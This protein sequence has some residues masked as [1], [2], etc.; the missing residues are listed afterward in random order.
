MPKSRAIDLLHPTG[1]QNESPEL[2]GNSINR[3]V[4][5][6][7]EHL[8][9]DARILD[10]IRAVVAGD[11]PARRDRYRDALLR[12]PEVKKR[13][14][15]GRSTIYNKIEAETFPKQIPLGGNMVGWYESDIDAWVENPT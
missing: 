13:T 3:L 5:A 14:G 10:A 15:L 9:S 8:V 4:S 1:P 2:D 12:L 7:A 11:A 6:I